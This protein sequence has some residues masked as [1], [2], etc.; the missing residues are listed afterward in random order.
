LLSACEESVSRLSEHGGNVLTLARLLGIAPETVADFSA[1]INPLGFSPLV[2]ESLLHSLDSLVH[3]PDNS[4]DELRR[5]LASYHRLPL[6][7]IT[8]A[9]GSTELIYKL[10]AVLPGKRALIIAPAFSEYGRALDQQQWEIEYFFLRPEN[11]FLLDLEKL[12]KALANG[13]DALY[14]CN[15]G[16]PSGTLYPPEVIKK[17]HRLCVV[18]GTFL[19]LDEA[20]MDFC[21]EA[22]AKQLAA[23]GDNCIVLRSMTK[24]FGIPGLRLGYSISNPALAGN[25]KNL[26]GPWSVN[27][28]ALNAGKAAL[29]D[30]EHNGSSLSF[31]SDERQALYVGLKRFSCLQPHDSRANFLLVE[32]L[33]GM[34]AAE[35]ADKLLLYRILI[36]DCANFRGLSEHFFRIAV[37]TGEENRRL[38]ECLGEIV[39]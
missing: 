33:N 5:A 32:I 18:S 35:L 24:F 26:G 37:R 12:R 1:S 10:P 11:N 4:H 9:N 36:R 31:V 28:L 17:V 21:E 7:S 20:F 25:L 27:T 16:N 6:S 15:P 23:E 38:L 2:R 30:I 8:I 14:L 39:K 3:Y 13:T 29:R 22:S 19:V 34:T